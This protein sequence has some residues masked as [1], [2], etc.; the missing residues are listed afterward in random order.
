MV[1]FEKLDTRPI[2]F[3]PG[4][5]QIPPP[6]IDPNIPTTDDETQTFTTLEKWLSTHSNLTKKTEKKTFGGTEE[7]INKKI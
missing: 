2:E 5:L 7:K 6:G 4:E 1:T 3:K